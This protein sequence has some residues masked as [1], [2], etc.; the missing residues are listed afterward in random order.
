MSEKKQ[1]NQKALKLGSYSAF[2]TLVVIAIV[3]VVN[4][5]F[6]ELPSTVTKFDTSNIKLYTLTDTTVQLLKGLNED[7]TMYYIVQNGSEDTSIEEMLNRYSSYSSRIK[8]QV[9][10]PTSNPN[11]SSRYTD[12]SL[13]NNSVIVESAKRSTVIDYT[14][15]YTTEYS[16]EDIYN[17]YMTGQMPSGTS[18]FY[19]ESC[20]TTALD[21][22]TS[23][24]L[25]KLYCITGHGETP[26]DE[27][28]QKDIKAENIIW[29]ELSLLTVTSI[30]N[31]AGSV[32]INTPTSDLSETEAQI[33]R[34]YL[35]AGG[36]LVLFT[37][38]SYCDPV[39]MPNLFSITA[40]YGLDPVPGLL[41]ES[42]SKYYT[43]SP[44]ILLPK[45]N[46]A[47][48]LAGNLTT[49]GITP[50]LAM[51]HGVEKNAQTGCYIE[52]LLSTSEDAY[53]KADPQNAETLEKEDG[54]RSGLFYVGV[55]SENTTN[56][57]KVLWYTS[58]VF[59]DSSFYAYNSE[60]FMS[61]L[62]LLCNKQSSIS[63]VGKAMQIQSLA[64]SSASALFWGFVLVILL[65]VGVVVFGF[66]VWNKRRKR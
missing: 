16:D 47:A 29:E 64:V 62:T 10:D 49:T 33:L 42:N 8:I 25:P 35:D 23:D 17:Y 13:S 34:S 26:L 6:G 63:I 36:K 31:D 15:I 32:L 46:D 60:L 50:I 51:A 12:S 22:V 1:T 45:L 43:Q 4:L 38:Y 44:Y 30:P 21:Y 11:F 54:D 19:G 48:E 27:S 40:A 28:V 53:V 5:M 7:V 24:D 55:S 20:L 9:V 61:N 3:I 58:P 37:A 39:T 14:E 41:I 18:Y 57:G 65:P 66:V 56:G 2:L 52:P 59:F